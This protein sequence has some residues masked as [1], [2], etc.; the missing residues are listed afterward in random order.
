MKI[1]ELVGA[2]HKNAVSKGWWQEERTYGELIALVHSEV[3]E[4]LEDFRNRKKPDEVWY[5]KE[6]DNDRVA[7]H[8]GYQVTPEYKPCGIPSELADICI[9]I[10]DIA[11]KYGWGGAMQE[12]WDE[13]FKPEIEKGFEHLKNE[14][15]DWFA[16]SSLPGQLSFVHEQLSDSS[17]AFREYHP[18]YSQ[19]CLIGVLMTVWYISED[20]G[21]D[22]DKAIAEKMAYNATRDVR[23][24]GKV[25]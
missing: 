17:K 8:A 2:A 25:I 18:G 11:G 10:F 23:H 9:R 6:S 15:E 20:N 12:D 16:D 1:I 14:T 21:I 22:L 7:Y 5:E 3:S 4:A 24:G 13:V 19:E